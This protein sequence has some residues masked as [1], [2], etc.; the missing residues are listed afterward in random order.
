VLDYKSGRV[1]AYAYAKLVESTT[2]QAPLYIQAVREGLGLDVAGAAYRGLADGA[3]RGAFIEDE[4][5]WGVSGRDVV[6]RGE[7]DGLVERALEIA[8]TAAR[9]I[10][11]GRIC[12]TGGDHCA[13]CPVG[14]WCEESAA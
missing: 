3:S 9:G 6:T 8:L 5:E 11:E 10:R 4:A 13:W 2:I 14:G 7:L 12:R 1:G